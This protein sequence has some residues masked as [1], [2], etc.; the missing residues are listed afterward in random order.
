MKSWTW[1]VARRFRTHF[2]SAKRP[3][4]GCRRSAV[5]VREPIV[6]FPGSPNSD[7]TSAS[8]HPPRAAFCAIFVPPI[9]PAR[10]RLNAFPA[11]AVTPP[12]RAPIAAAPAMPSK[13]HWPPI[14]K[15]MPVYS[16]ASV[17]AP[18][19][20]P[21]AAAM[22]TEPSAV[23]ARGNAAI[24]PVATM[25]TTTTARMIAP[26][27]LGSS[28]FHQF[29]T[30]PAAS[31]RQD[32]QSQRAAE[33]ASPVGSTYRRGLFDTYAFRFKVCG[34][35]GEPRTGSA[36]TNRPISG[37]YCRARRY[38]RPVGSSCLSI[39]YLYASVPLAAYG[40]PN[41]SYSV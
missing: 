12:T 13:D 17:T 11:P 4:S 35:D 30:A 39:A 7:R 23:P 21:T 32:P 26:R 27:T 15:V 36:L 34:A 37:S 41:G 1:F 8:Y 5:F 2:A 14:A 6:P 38:T 22:R 33:Q 40:L 3:K 24:P 28:P 9:I 18:I 31:P 10:H 29:P 25:A 20:A 16:A 19:A